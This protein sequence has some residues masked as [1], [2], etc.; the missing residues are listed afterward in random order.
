MR[1]AFALA[2]L[3]A[4]PAAAHVEVPPGAFHAGGIAVIEFT[5]HHG[6]DGAATTALQVRLPASLSEI[7]PQ[8]KAGW[9][10]TQEG[11]VLSWSGGEIAPDAPA[12]FRLQA[13]VARDAPARILLPVLQICGA[14]VQHWISPNPQASH[15]APALV[16][17]P[18]P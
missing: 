13:R 7:A 1:A 6:C 12:S 18:A 16:V 5:F 14:Q 15:P 10:V 17:L 9:Q 8:P 4:G 2:L 3:L 11:Q